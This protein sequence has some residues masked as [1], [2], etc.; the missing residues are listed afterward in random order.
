MMQ[1]ELDEAD[2]LESGDDFES[3]AFEDDAFSGDSMSELDELGEFDALD[4][5][6][7]LAESDALDELDEAGDLADEFEA[8]LD[9]DE[10]DG[11]DEFGDFAVDSASGLYVPAAPRLISGPAAVAIAN[12]LNPFVIESMDADDADAFFRRIG[13][14]LRR[15]GRGIGRAARGIGRVVGRVA[16]VAAPV[17]R[18]VLPMVQRVAGLAG[19]WGRLVSAGI[20]AARGL[21]SGRGLRGALAGAVGGLVPGVGG[22]LA[23]ALVGGGDGADD[24]AALDALAD[25]SDA[26]EVTPD[27]ALPLGAGLATRIATPRVAGNIP[28]E[29]AAP[30]AAAE[31]TMLHAATAA[32]GSTG[33]RLRLLRLIARLIRT[34]LR[35]TG[36]ARAAADAFPATAQRVAGRVLRRARRSPG[37]YASSRGAAMRRVNY[38]RRVVRS[39]PLAAVYRRPGAAARRRIR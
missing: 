5:S 16:R 24:D 38:R 6:D 18:R 15:I 28:P 12:R 29:I 26:G 1:T 19:P 34:H 13:R 30:A 20:G 4:E 10:V 37:M 9:A 39:V 3:D 8:E 17:L 21:A 36:S 22:R 2:L 11:L 31:Q 27:V 35:R 7:A 25:M 23:G 33:R 32:G 14:G